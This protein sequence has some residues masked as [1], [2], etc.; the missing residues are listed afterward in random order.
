MTDAETLMWQ[1]ERDP[2]MR[3]AFST[4][5]ILDR[6]PDIDAFRARIARAVRLIPRLL[7]RVQDVPALLGPPLWVPDLEF[8]LDYH[9]RHI[10][11]PPPGT[12]RQLLNLAALLHEQVL[13][14]AHPLW[15]FT[16]VV[17]LDG[18]RA[19][20]I[21]KM[22]HTI[23]D[24]VGAIRLS[25][26]FTDVEPDPDRSAEIDVSDLD[27]E[28]AAPPSLAVVA[29]DTARRSFTLGA[30]A[31]T[32][33]IGALGDPV[34][35][36]MTAI[37]V[38]RQA[39]A[40]GPGGSALWAGRRSTRREFEVVS[41]DLERA[42]Q[43]AK[44]LGGTLNDFLVTAVAGAAGE[45]HRAKGFVVDD[46]RAAIP[47]SIRADASA[48]GNA[49]VPTRTL[50]PA[51]DVEA[52]HRFK[53]VHDRLVSLKA[54]RS[55][56][57]AGAIA[58]VVSYLPG[59]VVRTLARSQTARVDFAVSNVRGAPFELFI[60]GAPIVANFPFGPTGATAFNATLLSYRGSMDIGINIDSAAVDEPALLRQ[61]L[62]D[63]I[64]DL[65]TTA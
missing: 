56:G 5:T 6:S 57:A 16:L 7:H 1:A 15:T 23:S 58:G 4:V 35:A 60:G 47:V 33:A 54:D 39:V 31:V 30:H 43:A 38:A 13:D 52:A 26:M 40:P 3:S 25:A 63:A 10:A 20:L 65:L 46:L 51:G 62:V 14:P 9:I 27:A 8:D 36:A 49:F 28:P 24:G 17:G 11:L 42:K 34:G 19:A 2:L 48:A 59:P 32:G 41:T 53:I 55:I 37:D 45:Y 18:D 22:H 50:V 21:T 12:E 44:A 61:L 29:L 64:D